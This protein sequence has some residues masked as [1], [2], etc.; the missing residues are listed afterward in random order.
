VQAG[1]STR[2]RE[3]RMPIHRRFG[4]RGP[5]GPNEHRNR[6]SLADPVRPRD[7]GSRYTIHYPRVC[8]RCG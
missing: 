8:C 3:T 4:R 5:G 2:F 1:F 7:R 6:A